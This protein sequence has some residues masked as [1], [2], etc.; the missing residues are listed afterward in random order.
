MNEKTG[1]F[2]GEKKEATFENVS[3]EII[4]KAYELY[5]K[6]H[7]PGGEDPKEYH[8]SGHPRRMERDGEQIADILHLSLK[9]RLLAMLGIAA[10]DL[11]MNYK[12]AD[13]NKVTSMISRHRGAREG[14][15]PM[16]AQGN[17]GKS[18]RW[19]AEEMRKA[20]EHAG[21]EIFTEEEIS[22]TVWGIDTTYPKDK[23]GA[24]FEEYPYYE[25][26]LQ[27]NQALGELLGELKEQGIVKGPLFS[28]PHLEKPL[29]EGTRVPREVLIVALTD[30][31]AVGTGGKEEFFKEGDN[32]MRE[33]L[34][35]LRIPEVMRRIS[36]GDEDADRADREEVT[37]T[38]VRWLD[39]QPGFA[40]WQALRF[41]KIMHLLKQQNGISPEEEQGMRNLFCHFVENIR[42]TRDRSLELKAEVERMKSSVGEKEA[43]LFLAR[44]MHYEI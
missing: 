27:Q 11:V 37:G 34:G 4:L 36:G 31:G 1:E 7:D 2:P 29:E 21:I 14:D 3:R 32:E 15:E 5:S 39:S 13:P 41:E 23:F 6:M 38:F 10:H 35:N 44:S 42:A 26:A 19:L 12:K 40:V 20:N 24:L 33:L 25:I 18:A 9:E 16:G 28:Q 8:V 30:L 43:F 22:N 17:A